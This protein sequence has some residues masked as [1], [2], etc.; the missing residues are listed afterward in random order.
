MVSGGRCKAHF[1]SIAA[2]RECE[3]SHEDTELAPGEADADVDAALERIPG[4]YI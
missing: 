2:A 4:S 1:D 3:F